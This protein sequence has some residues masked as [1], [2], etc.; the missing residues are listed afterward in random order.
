[1]KQEIKKSFMDLTIPIYF[2][3]DVMPELHTLVI[4]Q[5]GVAVWDGINW[6]TKVDCSRLIP[7]VEWW[8]PLIYMRGN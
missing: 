1:M 4:V 2:S 6:Y 7:P 8:S 5:G 3:K